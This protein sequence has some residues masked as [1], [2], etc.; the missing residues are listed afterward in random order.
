MSQVNSVICIISFNLHK[1][2]WDGS[3][4]LPKGWEK[5]GWKSLRRYLSLHHWQE[6]SLFSAYSHKMCLFWR[7]FTHL[8]RIHQKILCVK[9]N[10]AGWWEVSAITLKMDMELNS[11]SIRH[12]IFTGIFF[13]MERCWPLA[14]IKYII[15]L[16]LPWALHGREEFITNISRAAWSTELQTVLYL[17]DMLP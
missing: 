11:E 3:L 12:G 6:C 17:E 14:D 15:Y 9:C 16:S 2:L 10:A 13:Q 5:Q 7:R 4:F 1:A 8:R